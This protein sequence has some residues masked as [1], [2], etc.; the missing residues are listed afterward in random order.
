MLDRATLEQRLITL[1]QVVFDLQHNKWLLCKY[2]G[3]EEI[4]ASFI[5]TSSQTVF[6]GSYIYTYTSPPLHTVYATRLKSP[7]REIELKV[8]SETKLSSPRALFALFLNRESHTIEFDV[9]DKRLMFDCEK[10]ISMV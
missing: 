9:G 8:I 7:D 10:V 6:Y 4:V 1:E 3:F 5:D 2:F